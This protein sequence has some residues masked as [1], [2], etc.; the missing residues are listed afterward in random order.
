MPAVTADYSNNYDKRTI[1]YKH[2]RLHFD[3]IL[4]QKPPLPTNPLFC[5]FALDIS[6]CFAYILS[7]SKNCCDKSDKYA[8]SI[9]IEAA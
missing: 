2:F 7:Q 3:A 1:I 8:R 9:V 4:I 5:A 6:Y